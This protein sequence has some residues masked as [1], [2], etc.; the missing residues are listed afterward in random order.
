MK[1]FLFMKKFYSFLFF[2]FLTIQ[3]FAQTKVSGVVVDENYSPIAYATVALK[4]TSA[5]VITDENGRFYLESNKNVKILVVSFIG[6]ISREIVLEKAINYNTTIVL[7]DSGPLDEVKIYVGKT[8]K[9]DNPA[10]VILRK[11]WARKRKNG[12]RQFRQYELD[13]YEKVEFDLNSIDSNFMKNPVFK[14]MEFVFKDLDTSNITGKNYLP[15]FINESLYKVYADNKTAKLKEVLVANKNIGYG[16]NDQITAFIKD[17]YSDF[18]IYNNYLQ[19]YDKTFTSPLS[20]TG[21][22]VYNYVLADSAYIDKK[23]CYNIVFYPR[24]KNEL[25]FKGDFWVNDT[26]W[27]IKK[28]NMAVSKS[29]NINWVKDI[30]VEQEFEVLNDSV[31]LLTRD[32]MMSDFVLNKKDKSKGVYGKRTTLYRNH[33]FNIEKP[34]RFY[35]NQNEIPDESVFRKTDEFWEENRFEKLNKDET[36][37][38]KLLDTLKTTRSFVKVA[39]GIEI[40]SSGYINV[41][42]TSFDYGPIFSTFGYNDVEGLRVRTG[43]RTYFGKDDPW[44]LE[45]YLAYGFR[46]DKFKFGVSGKWMIENSKR[47][48]ISAGHKRDIEQMGASLTYSNDVLGRSFAS[49]SLF[50]IGSNNRLTNV[51]LSVFSLEFEPFVNFRLLGGLTRK[52]LVSASPEFSLNYYT[53]LPDSNGNGG[54]VKSDVV[55]S[56]INFQLDFTPKRANVGHGVERSYVDSPHPRFFVN[57]NRGFQGILGS[58]FSYSKL[59]LYLKKPFII[60]GLGRL[61]MITEAGKIFGTVPLG[62]LSI[63]PG[64]QT[65]FA[66]MNTFNLLN[67]Y[68]FVA[69]QYATIQL[70]HNFGGRILSRIPL[71]RKLNWR[72]TIGV[73]GIIASVSDENKAINASGLVYNSPE[74][75]YWEYNVGIGNIFRL[76]RVE[77]SWRGNYI[78]HETR[79]YGFKMA[80]GFHF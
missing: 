79:N 9:K 55:Q 54:V 1:L 49:A 53:T 32:H 46:D 61:D 76:F 28:I 60:G 67:Y 45:S 73:N 3:L 13:K 7:K 31:F 44:R 40:L 48:I 77:F 59:Q 72:E 64:N 19:F 57:Y 38:Y 24:R 16:N 25:T 11:I 14:G 29:A 23:K 51:D 21:I 6:Y 12:L 36:K 41:K 34:Q 56:E 43:G 65:Y 71:M 10:L 69:D 18:D 70:Q 66:A 30:Y 4:G 63:A 37:V 74:K 75:A 15:V 33:Q 39:K 5:G 2:F 52:K 26:T 50:T 22:D 27:A 62:L 17:L 68:E 42:N 35:R 20:R 80:Y 47:V 58:D 8:S 78:S